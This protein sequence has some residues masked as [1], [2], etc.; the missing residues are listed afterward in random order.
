MNFSDT[1]D[2]R[3]MTN[4]WEA[5]SANMYLP[6]GDKVI[7]QDSLLGKSLGQK[8]RDQRLTSSD[9][10]ANNQ[11]A[12]DH[13]SMHEIKNFREHLSL[14]QGLLEQLGV[15]ADD[16]EL[17][18]AR[19][20]LLEQR[21]EEMRLYYNEELN[22]LK[23]QLII[24]QANTSATN[25]PRDALRDGL[26]FSQLKKR[27]SSRNSHRESRSREQTSS[28]L[29]DHGSGSREQTSSRKEVEERKEHPRRSKSTTRRDS[30]RKDQINK[31]KDDRS[32]RESRHDSRPDVIAPTP[33]SESLGTNTRP[34]PVPTRPRL[35]A[36]RA[37]SVNGNISSSYP[38]SQSVRWDESQESLAAQPKQSVQFNKPIDDW[39]IKPMTR[40]HSNHV[41]HETG[42]DVLSNSRIRESRSHTSEECTETSEDL[43]LQHRDAFFKLPPIS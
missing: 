39:E 29:P 1:R 27:D 19:I 15:L 5:R 34:I 33:P 38:S 40:R 17:L 4:T 24:F 8:W 30:E 42:V 43:L 41:S 18:R 35:E 7:R 32:L 6:H 14:T 21:Q 9:I 25:S 28:R 23:N 2:L 10:T 22:F 3:S 31:R 12:N 37:T 11:T 36:S 16:N 13:I 26:H 20:Q